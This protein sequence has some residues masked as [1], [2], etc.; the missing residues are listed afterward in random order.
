MRSQI[1]PRGENFTLVFESMRG[2]VE[3]HIPLPAGYSLEWG[4]EYEGSQEARE[5][6]GT[7]IPITFAV[8]CF[9]SPC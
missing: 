8:S 3:V 2:D 7:K 4:G 9:L 1:P 6:L 5:T